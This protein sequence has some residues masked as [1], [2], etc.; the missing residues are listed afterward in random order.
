MQVSIIVPLYFYNFYV[1]EMFVSLSNQ[2]YQNFEIIVVGNGVDEILF[3]KI[4]K[5]IKLFFLETKCEIKFYFTL[6]K[7][8]NPA[9]EFGLKKAT[10]NY[11]FFLDSDDQFCESS[12]LS[13]AI[14][15]LE[16]KKPDILSVN[17]QRAVFEQDKLKLNSIVYSFL[18]SDEL[19]SIEFHKEIILNNY[20][21]NICARFIKRELLNNITF[22][23]LP[24]CQDWNVS[25]KLFCNTKTFYFMSEPLYIWLF[26]EES[27]S[28]VSSMNFDK[29]YNSFS[30]IIDVVE[31]YKNNNISE[32]FTYFL[33]DRIIK[34]CFQYTARSGYFNINEGL[35][36]SNKFIRQEV[37][38][39]KYFFKN[40]RIVFMYIMIKFSFIYK[41]YFK[42][43]VKLD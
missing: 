28:K 25:S 20:G 7:G 43:W 19:L 41:L 13:K 10:G 26:R 9:R 39:N 15:V 3:N 18:N 22:L 35:I 29:H 23:D 33:N 27:V 40:K 8:A 34:F 38:F 24:Y 6:I 2:S 31:Y 5:E 30:S 14:K 37:I 16:E 4:K 12:S 11:V 32:K 1:K 42:Y 36:R 21:T 17:I